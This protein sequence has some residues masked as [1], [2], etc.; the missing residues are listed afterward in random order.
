MSDRPTTISVSVR[1]ESVRVVA[2]VSEMKYPDWLPIS[3]NT[4]YS[5]SM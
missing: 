2:Y 5:E 1:D 4:M 3:R